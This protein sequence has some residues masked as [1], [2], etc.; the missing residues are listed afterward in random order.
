MVFASPLFLF[1]LSLAVDYFVRLA[2]IKFG[3]YLFFSAV[4]AVI[5]LAVAP[6]LFNGDGIFDFLANGDNLTGRVAIWQVMFSFLRDHLWSGG[7]YGSIWDVGLGT[8]LLPYFTSWVELAS[9]GHNGY[10]DTVVSM[11]IPGLLLCLLAFFVS[12]MSK[13]KACT[14][15]TAP[16]RQ[17]IGCLFFFV[18]AHNFFESNIM[19]GPQAASWMLLTT[20]CAVVSHASRETKKTIGGI[21]VNSI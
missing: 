21:Y 2:W 14:T 4:L 7:G 17:V 13:L 8:P 9:H 6:L 10:I 5:P 18:F 16:T 1:P 3:P 20:L 15:L 19:A 12:P 11:G